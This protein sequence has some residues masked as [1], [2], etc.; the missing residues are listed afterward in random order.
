MVIRRKKKIIQTDRVY[1]GRVLKP[2]G[3]KGEV[4]FHSFSCPLDILESIDQFFCESN[5][6]KLEIEW[7]RGAE[8]SLIVKFLT[9]ETRDMAD[10]LN[11]EVLWVSEGDLPELN[12][13]YIY[14]SNLL[15]AE[16]YTEDGIHVGTV[17]DIIET[18]ATDVM[19]IRGSQEHMIPVHT[20]WI[21]N[22]DIEK[23]TITVK[24]LDFDESEV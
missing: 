8:D 22:L 23:K 1:I 2:H 10:E 3:L 14:A 19:V 20:E 7:I 9:I 15:Y 17:E 12:E 18:G 4:K 16:A 13:E 5:Q 6:K 11:G 21:L 24:L